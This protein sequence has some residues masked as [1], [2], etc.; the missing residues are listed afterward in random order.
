MCGVRVCYS[1]DY[2]QCNKENERKKY[3]WKAEEGELQGRLEECTEEDRI[4]RNLR[5]VWFPLIAF[6]ASFR[7][8]TAVADLFHRNRKFDGIYLELESCITKERNAMNT[9]YSP[10]Q[11]VANNWF[12]S[13]LFQLSDLKLHFN[14]LMMVIRRVKLTPVG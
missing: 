2:K 7:A 1:K 4:I 12:K 3:F 14:N 8:I 10:V 9:Q 5:I 13:L 6:P 11:H